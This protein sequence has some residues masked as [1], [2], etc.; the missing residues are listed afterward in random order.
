M[1]RLRAVVMGAAVGAFGGLV[2]AVTIAVS[3]SSVDAWAHAWIIAVG[4]VLVQSVAVLVGTGLGLLLRPAVVAFLA[5]IV[6]PLGLWYVLG[7][8]DVLRP[9]QA[10]LTP[11]PSVRKLLSGEVTALS[12]GRWL[13]VLALWDV[14]LIAVGAAWLNRRQPAAAEPVSSR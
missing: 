7:A 12:W 9:V 2:S 4:G 6:L 14:G 5:T 3:A 1:I 8:V 10:W 11:Y 13:V